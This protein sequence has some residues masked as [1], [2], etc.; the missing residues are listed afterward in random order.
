[1]SSKSL[2]EIADRRSRVRARIFAAGTLVFL[3][4][5]FITMPGFGSGENNHGW[6]AYMWMV[7]A[8]L[9]LLCLG[10]GGGLL[11]N[12]KVRALVNDE[13]SR[14]NYHRA[15]M[16]GFWVAMVAGLALYAVP[17]WQAFTGHQVAYIIV[18]L[19]TVVALL[20]FSWLEHRA[21]D[22]A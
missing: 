1:M 14:S 4:V 16:L 9:L 22:D 7:N 5:Q 12:R 3:S 15:C 13:V 20:K 8:V 19:T 10:T 11:T 17:A 2:V 6:R 18:T 21:H